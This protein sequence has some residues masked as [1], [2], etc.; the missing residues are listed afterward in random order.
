MV[1]LRFLMLM[2]LDMTGKF[3]R[4]YKSNEKSKKSIDKRKIFCKFAFAKAMVP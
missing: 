1:A 2:V 4:H 3:N